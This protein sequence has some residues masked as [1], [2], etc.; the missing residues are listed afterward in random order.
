MSNVLIEANDLSDIADAIRTKTGESGTYKVSQMA[1]AI[2]SIET[3]GGS[4]SCTV[5][6]N[7][8]QPISPSSFVSCTIYEWDGGSKGSQIG[9]IASPT[10]STSV[11]TT[12][13]GIE[14]DLMGSY[15]APPAYLGNVWGSGLWGFSYYD[16]G[17]PA[18]MRFAIG[19][20]CEINISGI[21]W[22]D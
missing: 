3:G 2:D 15:V 10:G 16:E 20:D 18:V 5:S 6:I 21:D 22:N 19:G 9:T 14:L 17:G 11:T 8:T 4:V 1:D 7:L 12:T 13:G